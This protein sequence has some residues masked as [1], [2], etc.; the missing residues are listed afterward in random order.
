MLEPWRRKNDEPINHQLDSNGMLFIEEA[1]Q[2]VRIVHAKL[3]RPLPHRLGLLNLEWKENEIMRWRF[4]WE[5][6]FRELMQRRKLCLVLGLKLRLLY[7]S[8]IIESFLHWLV[9]GHWVSSLPY[10][11]SKSASKMTIHYSHKISNQRN[12]NWV[13][14]LCR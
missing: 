12:R 7:S 1:C 4:L 8:L 10:F 6:S 3:S 5:V 13:R 9:I 14:L 2:H 11:S